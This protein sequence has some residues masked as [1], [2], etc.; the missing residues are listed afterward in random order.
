M[1][2]W[3]LEEVHC[4]TSNRLPTPWRKIL[5]TLLGQEFCQTMSFP[6]ILVKSCL[7]PLCF[8]AFGLPTLED[9]RLCFSN[10]AP[11]SKPS[12]R[13]EHRASLGTAPLAARAAA[14]ASARQRLGGPEWEVGSVHCKAHQGASSLWGSWAC[15][16]VVVL[17]V[18]RSFTAWKA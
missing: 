6:P 14:A 5:N 12:G 8:L 15:S 9:H 11:R 2:R 7:R 16:S 3:V 18:L 17:C 10:A 4:L 13:H 1:S